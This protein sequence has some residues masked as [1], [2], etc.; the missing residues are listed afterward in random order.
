MRRLLVFL[1][2]SSFGLGAQNFEFV[3]FW[4]YYGGIESSEGYKNLRSRVFVRPRFFGYN[5]ATGLE[6]SLSANLWVQPLGEEYAVNPWDIL[7]ET[8]LYLPLDN[9]DF[10]LG[11]KLVTYGF[12]DVYGPLNVLHSRNRAALSIDEAWDARRPDPMLQM[13]IFPTLEDTIE[14]TYV[15]VTR[16]DRE[17]KGPVQLPPGDNPAT[18]D[19]VQWSDDPYILDNPH[20]FFIN[21][22]R[23]GIKS[24]WQFFYGYYTDHTP[25]F[26]VDTV[27]S[28]V[29]SVITPVYNKKHSLGL[30]YSTRLGKL[31]L[32][33]DLALTLTR[34]LD[35]TD[36]GAA[37]SDITLNTQLLAQLKGG[38]L[39]QFSLITAFFINHG[40]H[41]KHDDND[42]DITSPQEKEAQ[43]LSA[44]IQSFHNQ[45]LPFIAVLVAHFEKA[46]FR[47]RLKTQLNLALLGPRVLISPRF[48]FAL[49]DYWGV[50][51]GMDLTTDPLFNPESFPD[52]D[53]RRNPVNDNFYFRMIY[54]Y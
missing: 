51:T 4:D 20:S 27:D 15:P 32:S 50:E 37:N 2:L 35:G 7:H 6:W 12:A 9:F 46:F 24:D 25:D 43:Y 44:E 53:L 30:A 47:N 39:S 33:Q 11:Q 1:F 29:A 26:K 3:G 45:P 8:W 38:I 5:D 54:R 21:Y 36:I 40:K 14:L 41:D 19:M 16:P 28:S 18:A 48:A 31:T 34:D 23:Y 13:R 17:R 42:P 22:N 10:T 49:S 52:R